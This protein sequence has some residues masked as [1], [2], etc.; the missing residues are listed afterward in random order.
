[1]HYL[2]EF[3]VSFYWHKLQLKV[4]VTELTV[5]TTSHIFHWAKKNWLNNMVVEILKIIENDRV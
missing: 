5:Y 3:F 4:K 1:M 2:I